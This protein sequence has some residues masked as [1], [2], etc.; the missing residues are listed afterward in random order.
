M[1]SF[2]ALFLLMLA[3]LSRAEVPAQQLIEQMAQSAHKLDYQGYFIYERGMQSTSYQIV[4]Q[5]RDEQEKQRLVFLDGEPFEVINDGHS[6][7]CIHPG[8]SNVQRIEHKGL[9]AWLKLQKPLANIWH[10]YQADVLGKS[11]I[12]GRPVTQIQ[13]QPRDQHR[14]PFIFYVD[15]ETGM[16]L[17]MLMLDQKGKLLERFRYV[18]IDYGE[19]ADSALEPQIQNYQVADHSTETAASTQL[20]AQLPAWQLAWV[21]DGFQQEHNQMQ[22]WLQDEHEHQHQALMYSDGLSAFSVFI[23]PVAQAGQGTS[24]RIGSTAIVSQ[25]I[26]VSGQVF[27]VTVIGE[28]PPMTAQQIAISVRPAP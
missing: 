10:Y 15:D 3:A 17:K 4:H 20:Q 18:K 28:I 23:E 27:L 25:Y 16:M 22:L 19:V 8:S 24:K 14:Y 9:D 21:P 12:A 5:V 11:R 26:K 6:F 7:Q 13:L 1:R 2:S